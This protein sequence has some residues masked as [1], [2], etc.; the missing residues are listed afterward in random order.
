MSAASRSIVLAYEDQYC[1]ALHLFLKRLRRDRGLPGIVLEP[2]P[3]R[4][5]GNFAREV[6]KIL[7]LP[8]K[9]TRAPPDHVVCVGDADKPANLTS[10]APPLPAV[11]TDE[12]LDAWIL[13]LERTWHESLVRGAKLAA[14]DSVRVRA[15]CLR[16]N[17]ESL[18]IASPEALLD[19]AKKYGRSE[20]VSQW[21]A[22]RCD[23]SPFE[24]DDRKFTRT[25]RR[26][27]VCMDDV[28]HQIAGRKYKKGVDDEDILR[29]HIAEE[30]VRRAQVLRRSPDLERLLAALA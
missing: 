20:P 6:P 10:S 4:G 28:V 19:H 12:T 29:H 23:P 2:W 15:V 18:L 26:P 8:L 16:W 7:R 13:D 17:K 25:Y 3:V 22:T 1:D 21:L 11:Q 9:Q 14:T 30:Q 27:S 24:L 5:T